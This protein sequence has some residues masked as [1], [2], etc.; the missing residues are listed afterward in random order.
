MPMSTV[1]H[2]LGSVLEID[3]QARAYANTWLN[4]QSITAGVGL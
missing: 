1:V 4:K 2:D 3:Q